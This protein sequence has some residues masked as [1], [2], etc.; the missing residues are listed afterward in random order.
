MALGIFDVKSVIEAVD[1]SLRNVVGIGMVSGIVFAESGLLFGFFLPGDSLLLTAGILASQGY[2]N[3]AFLL[4]F[5]FV[6]AVV[7]DN[8]GYTTGK[9]LGRRLFNKKE[10]RVFKPEHL[11]S[12]QNFYEKHGGKTII[13][14]RFVPLIRT[15]AP[16]VAGM[17][18]MKYSTFF[19]YNLVG[20]LLWA[21]GVT[22]IGYFLGRLIPDVDKYLL[23]VIGVVVFV[24]MLPTFWHVFKEPENRQTLR[25]TVASS[26][27]KVRRRKNV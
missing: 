5:S 17:G 10:S 12:A 13:L 14:A 23:L 1:P 18:N 3:I 27:G 16:I 7:G 11:V 8:V 26:Y 4:V 19:L 22:L 24:S 2:I 9:R 25:K 6:A 20:G 15:F 21:V